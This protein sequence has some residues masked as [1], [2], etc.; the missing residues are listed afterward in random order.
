MAGMG[1]VTRPPQGEWLDTWTPPEP[2]AL[3]DLREALV[4]QMRN[5]YEHAGLTRMLQMGKGTLS[6]RT[7][8]PAR[9]ARIL[10]DEE[11]HRLSDAVLYFVSADMTRG[12]A[13]A[14]VP[15]ECA[16]RMHSVRMRCCN[17]SW[18]G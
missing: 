14:H 1:D 9:D 15:S 6:P 13:G 3:P 2:R 18:F 4:A 7:G 11:H 8:D 17:P 5:P 10:L 16:F 12:S